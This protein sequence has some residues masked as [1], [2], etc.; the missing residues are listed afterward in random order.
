MLDVEM[1]KVFQHSNCAGIWFM[2]FRIK[3]K[4]RV[5]I[6]SQLRIHRAS[7]GTVLNERLGLPPHVVGRFHSC[8]TNSFLGCIDDV[9]D[10]P[11][12]DAAD[13][14]I[15]AALVRQFAELHAV[16]DGDLRQVPKRVARSA[17]HRLEGVAVG[18]VQPEAAVV[19][20]GHLAG[21]VD[22]A[23]RL[24]DHTDAHLL[25]DK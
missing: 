9:L 4:I 18:L 22:G 13:D 14:E 17:G 2:D 8:D 20:L 23:G 3:V 5:E 12:D 24:V 19:A 15:A 25:S 21:A 11:V 6:F 16:Y 7:F 1:V 10:L